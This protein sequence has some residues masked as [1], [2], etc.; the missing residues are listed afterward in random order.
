MA[1]AL[2][3]AEDRLLKVSEVAYYL[4]LSAMTVYRLIR[5]EELHAIRVG[6]S[7]RVRESELNSYLAQA[8]Q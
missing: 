5:K 7:W 1:E 2:P 6:R 4:R 8:R 3:E